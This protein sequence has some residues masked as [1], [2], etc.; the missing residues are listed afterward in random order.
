MK[1]QHRTRVQ[2]GKG[3]WHSLHSSQHNTV[4]VCVFAWPLM[5]SAE[6][7]IVLVLKVSPLGHPFSTSPLLLLHKMSCS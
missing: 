7:L 6:L 5:A 3:K 4:M 1:L 2:E